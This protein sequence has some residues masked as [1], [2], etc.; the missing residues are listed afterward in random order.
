MALIEKSKILAE[1]APP[2]DPFLASQLLDE[3]VS[4]ERRFIQ[5]D[6][7]PA[8]LDGG[9]FCEVTARII[10]HMDSGNLNLNKDFDS[11]LQYVEEDK[12]N[13]AIQ[14]RRDALH[15]AKVLR[16]IYK[17]RSQRGAI[18]ISPTYTPNHM[19]SKLV[20]EGV[21]WAMNDLLRLFWG[22][23]REAV[24]KAI[25]ELLQFDVPC[26]GKFEDV[27]LVQR[28]DLTPEEEVLVLLHYAGE[29]GFSRTTIGKVAQV[30]APA[31]TRALQ[32]LISP[33]MRQA[34]KIGNGNYRLTDLGAKRIRE[35]LAEKL[36]VC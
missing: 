6:W 32:A 2:L 33:K 14:P 5:R 35:Q 23:D 4:S 36:L 11:C 13:H 1:I 7:E 29:E 24:A 18:H 25:R 17:F 34:V 12:S 31:V 27:L 19:D 16:T 10:Y 30:P 21:R 9:Q 8:Q 26:I 3:F 15:I 20:I 22:G 28:T